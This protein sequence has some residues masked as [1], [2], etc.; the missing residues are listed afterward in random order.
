MPNGYPAG[1]NGNH[2]P[3]G[4]PHQQVGSQAAVPSVPPLIP[5]FNNDLIYPGARFPGG[6]TYPFG[7]SGQFNNNQSG[8]SGNFNADWNYAQF[9]SRLPRF[10]SAVNVTSLPMNTPVTNALA[11]IQMPLNSSVMLAAGDQS[12]VTGANN[13]SN[14]STSESKTSE[15]GN[16]ENVLNEDGKEKSQEDITNEIA[17]KVSTMLSDSTLMQNA[18]SKIQCRTPEKCESAEKGMEEEELSIQDKNVQQVDGSFV[19]HGQDTSVT[20]VTENTEEIG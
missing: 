14:G 17:R 3:P 15:S 13:C 1:T 8:A 5:G 20:S 2:A 19:D 7:I 12:V 6:P 4:F 18:I 11:N 10:N 16:H 9:M